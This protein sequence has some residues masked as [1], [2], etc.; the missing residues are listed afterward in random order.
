MDA[1]ESYSSFIDELKICRNLREHGQQSNLDIT[2]LGVLYESALWRAFRAYENHIERTFIS[3]LIGEPGGDGS[4]VGCYASPNDHGHAR[5]LLAVSTSSRFVDWSEP[6]VIIDRCGAFFHADDPIYSAV[7][8]S[9]QVLVWAKKIRNQIA[10]NSAESQLQYRGVLESILLT[11]PSPEPKVG[12][13]LQI[14]PSK[15]P[16]KGREVLAFFLDSI[17]ACGAAAACK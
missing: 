5:K 11:F 4:T 14:I 8:G 16:V 1:A 15:G 13:L 12:E 9:R 3:Y 7:T 2:A 6:N 17:S 10:H